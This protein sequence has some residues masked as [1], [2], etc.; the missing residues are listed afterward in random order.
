MPPHSKNT[1]I[2]N[3]FISVQAPFHY[4]PTDIAE[5]S[6]VYTTDAM[7]S[8]MICTSAFLHEQK[9]SGNGCRSLMI[10]W[11]SSTTR[12]VG[13]ALSMLCSITFQNIAIEN[14]SRS[15]TV[16]TGINAPLL[17]SLW[18]HSPPWRQSRSCGGDDSYAIPFCVSILSNNRSLFIYLLKSVYIVILYHLAQ[19]KLRL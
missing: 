6:T 11:L 13:A 17:A 4:N 7:S 19:L 8:R 14:R 2:A 9:N 3:R 5:L 1:V 16:L 15:S 18:W 10:T 12:M